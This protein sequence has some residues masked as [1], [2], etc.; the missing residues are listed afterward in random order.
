MLRL[1]KH[2]LPFLILLLASLGGAGCASKNY[3]TTLMPHPHSFDAVQAKFRIGHVDAP[4]PL[5]FYMSGFTDSAY[6]A[7]K[8]KDAALTE[9]FPQQLREITTEKYPLL[10][11]DSADALTVDVRFTIAEYHETSTGSSFL[12][13]VS[14]GI[15]GIV[16][17]LPIIMQYDCDIQIS[18]P[19][20]QTEQSTV[21]R[22]RLAS[23]VSFPSPLAL[24]P[25]P[26]PADR[27]AVVFHPFQTKHYSGRLFTLECFGE[28]VVQAI[29]KLDTNKIN[30][31][32]LARKRRSGTATN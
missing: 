23:W 6:W 13:A 20:L 28:A 29:E 27:R 9:Q 4:P 24:I 3:T 5:I 19:D 32:Y 17:P 21:F 8:V 12:A 26:A 16:L 2:I 31:A 7:D 14:W 11:T 15:F 30:N 1:K 25:M 10:F 18:F 22:N